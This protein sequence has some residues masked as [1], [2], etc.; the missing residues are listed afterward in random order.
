MDEREELLHEDLIFIN[1]EAQSKEDLLKKLS[2]VLR[3]K[4]YVKDSYTEGI[5]QREVIYPTGLNTEAIKVAIPHT[6]AVH[7]NKSTI[8]VAVL[9]NTVTFKEMGNGINDVDANLIFMLA[10]KNPNSQVATL[11]KLM[12][13]L[14][15]KERL[16]SIYNSKTEKEVINV[17]SQVLN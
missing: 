8:L 3:E 14:S 16:L 5:L 7:V 17:L 10:I 11:S 9:N 4:G 1:Y 12:S 15:N 6:D 2:Q 13:I